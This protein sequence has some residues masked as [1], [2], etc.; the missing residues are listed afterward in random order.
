MTTKKYGRILTKQARAWKEYAGY[1]A[2]QQKKEQ[3]WE[4]SQNEKLIMELCVF[5]GDNRRRDTHNLHKLIADSFE[6]ILYDD[7]KYLLMR[8]MDFDIDKSNPRVEII[9]RKLNDFDILLIRIFK[10]IKGV[11]L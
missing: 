9:I 1:I 11:I 7:D 8:D 2:L 4:Y 6:G 5:W 3:G 10:T